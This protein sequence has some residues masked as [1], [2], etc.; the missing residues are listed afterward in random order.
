M[1]H[2]SCKHLLSDNTMSG[3]Q[4][5]CFQ[6]FENGDNSPSVHVEV[7][8][9]CLLLTR[10]VQ[11]LSNI[12]SGKQYLVKP[13]QTVLHSSLD[14]RKRRDFQRQFLNHFN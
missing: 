14:E 5:G 2:D 7:P 11:L 3:M 4:P 8:V 6:G 13:E 1:F 12:M 9:Q 10:Y